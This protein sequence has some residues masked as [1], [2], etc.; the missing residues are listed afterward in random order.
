M[1]DLEREMPKAIRENHVL[2]IYNIGSDTRKDTTLPKEFYFV[3]YEHTFD[4]FLSGEYSG[5]YCG[6][7]FFGAS[8][9]HLV[10]EVE[11]DSLQ[12][13]ELPYLIPESINTDFASFLRTVAE[14]DLNK[15]TPTFP[16]ISKM[17]PQYGFYNHQLG[18]FQEN[19]ELI[20]ERISP[21]NDFYAEIEIVTPNYNLRRDL[22]ELRKRIWGLHKN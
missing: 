8:L 11:K 2:A 15:I 22:I 17:Y 4:K 10:T 18:W 9:Q 3:I 5:C 12:F 16:T 19:R 6:T 1:F 13:L 20:S 7:D 21:C 14:V